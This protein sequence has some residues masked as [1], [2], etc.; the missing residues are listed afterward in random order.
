[1][2]KLIY[3]LSALVALGTASS[4]KKFVDINTNPNAPTA[5]DAASLLPPIQAGMERGVWYDSRYIGQYAQIWGSSAANNVWDEEGYVPGSDSNG[6]MW[7]TIYFSIG[8]N[9]NLMIQDATA[10]NKYEYLGVAHALKAWGWQNGADIYN[11]MVVKEAYD[12]TKLTFDYDDP[13]TVYAE[14]VKECRL[15]LGFFAQA[16]KTDNITGVSTTLA[17]GDYMYAGDRSKWV[18]FIYSILAQN[19]LHMSNKSTF[20]ADS[21]A[22]FVDHSFMNNGDNASVQNTATNSTDANFWGPTR[23]NLSGFRQSDFIVRLLDG[24]ILAGSATQDTLADPRLPL[25]LNRSKD[26]VYR[27]VIAPLGDVN[28]ADANTSIPAFA[29]FNNVTKV[30]TAKYLFNDNARGVL[31]TYPVLQF[32]KSEAL[33]KKGDMAGAYT[34]Y[35]NGVKGALDF[36]SNPPVAGSLTG[37]TN[38]ISA[39]DQAK[40]LASK[41]VAQSASALK[42]SDIL[43][44]KF[45]ALFLWNPIEAWSDERR[46]SYDATI[47]QGFT[48]PGTLYPD[49]AGKQV[50][51]VRPRYN[52]EYIWNVPALKKFGATAADYH[53]TKPWFVLP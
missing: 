43:Q 19:A 42:L 30:G 46:Y 11:Y 9:A 47:F 32:M 16:T 4:C 26:R 33:F 51:V 3:T 28:S 10:K 41:S 50:Y 24:R 21:V 49:N 1:M 52:S 27:G 18:K 45:I 25:L 8:Q 29:G 53:T 22:Y 5:V 37:A 34:A 17:K 15:A 2:K 36:A 12:P 38:Y 40:Y 48:K 23:G 13:Q 20:N 6:E 31:M 44:Q 39:A 14:A 35:I 7:R